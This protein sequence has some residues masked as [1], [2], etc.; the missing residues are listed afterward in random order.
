METIIHEL[1]RENIRISKDNVELKNSLESSLQKNAVLGEQ[2]DMLSVSCRKYQED[3]VKLF[4]TQQTMDKQRQTISELEGKLNTGTMKLSTLE[5]KI[6]EKDMET[7]LLLSESLSK[8][9]RIK[10]MRHVLL[11]SEENQQQLK[12]MLENFEMQTREYEEFKLFVGNTI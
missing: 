3:L 6:R 4:E 1:K 11:K 7:A 2:V 12:M 10:E 9:D 5:T 8:E